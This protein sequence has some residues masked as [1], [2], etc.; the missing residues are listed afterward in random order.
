MISRPYVIGLRRKAIAGVL[1]T[2]IIFA[3]LF[4]IGVGFL[5]FQ[6]QTTLSAN[7]ANN[8]RQ[9]AIQQ[10]SLEKL[11]L[12][13]SLSGSLLTLSLNNRGGVSTTI[14]DV[15]VTNSSGVLLQPP[16][17]ISNPCLQPT[18]NIGSS[19]SCTVTLNGYTYPPGTTVYLS[20]ITARGNTFTL[21]YPTP[22]TTATTTVTSTT[23]TAV[24]S[25][26]PFVGI[27]SNALVVDMA[28]SP[29]EA[30]TCTNGCVLVNATVYNYQSQGVMSNVALN[31][32]PPTV[33]LCTGNVP[34]C[35]ATLT[36]CTLSGHT[37]VTSPPATCSGPF[38]SNHTPDSSDTIPPYS[39]SGVA[40][41]VYF[42]CYYNA[43]TGVV[44]GFA[45]FSGQATGEQGST[46][47]AS[48]LAT[49]N[50][51]KIGGS[52]NVLNQG[53]F[54]ANFFYFH[55]TDCTSSHC[56]GS[57]ESPGFSGIPNL[58]TGPLPNGYLISG[59]SY[60]VS[61]YIQITNNFNTSLP[62]LQYTYFQTDSTLGNDADFFI[63]GPASNSSY[64]SLPTNAISP[65]PTY[66][67]T[68]TI[69]SPSLQAYTGSVSSCNPALG[70]SISN[71][72]DVNP[73]KTVTLTLAACNFGS[74]SWD[75]YNQPN[76]DN[77]GGGSIGCTI[78]GATTNSPSYTPSEATWL[79]IIIFF[80]FNGQVYAQQ[81]PF[82]G[83]LVCNSNC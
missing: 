1:A 35:T 70:G 19:D 81:I 45:T 38:N 44:G 20:V 46:V 65:S 59:N 41:D 29:P 53:P 21:Q 17:I 22:S 39:G 76:G 30:F 24:T 23:G 50:A 69:S 13:A 18:L 63:V 54:S 33:T 26:L 43:N 12:S 55:Y 72:I 9:N 31:P 75:W 66:Y 10:A 15:F 3:A 82:A 60:Y 61:Y 5:I 83:D 32:N 67:P 80:I 14:I 71:C 56:S 52:A 27:G 34:G 2:I 62:I 37:C 7:Q 74:N 77:S 48:A 51:I 79:G 68:Y 40:P 49:S 16:G 73:G 8:N 25:T 64:Y 42:L 57:T 11:S 4:S 78:N 6:N 36:P 58:P 28:A 47:I